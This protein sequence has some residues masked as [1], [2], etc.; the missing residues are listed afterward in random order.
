M[1]CV[2]GQE[3]WGGW[4]EKIMRSGS[5]FFF[6]RFSRHL[7]YNGSCGALLVE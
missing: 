2:H 6:K 1:R 3:V 5:A 4:P 7:C